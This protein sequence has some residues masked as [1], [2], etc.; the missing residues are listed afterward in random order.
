MA[1]IMK[2]LVKTGKP[3]LK[4]WVN[5]PDGWTNSSTNLKES[6]SS[7]TFPRAGVQNSL[8]LS[9]ISM[10]IICISIR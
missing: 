9:E 8:P 4:P 1:N 3:C 10:Q 2:K 7:G 5:L 6:Y